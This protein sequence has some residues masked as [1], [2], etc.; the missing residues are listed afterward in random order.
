MVVNSVCL[1]SHRLST[2]FLS[3]LNPLLKLIAERPGQLNTYEAKAK[4]I[5]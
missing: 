2:R 1:L 5:F 4:T 3:K